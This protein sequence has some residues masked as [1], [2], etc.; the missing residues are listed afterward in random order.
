[1][2]PVAR[3]NERP[4]T[5]GEVVEAFL[6][7]ALV[8]PEKPPKT[9]RAQRENRSQVIGFNEAQETLRAIL[10]EHGYD[11]LAAVRSDRQTCP[12]E[13]DGIKVWLT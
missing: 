1:M 11:T 4:F 8:E 12:L 9:Q 3:A 10:A 2:T 6:S 13:V 5:L 7:V